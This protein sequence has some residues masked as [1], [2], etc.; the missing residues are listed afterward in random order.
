MSKEQPTADNLRNA[1]D[2]RLLRDAA[3]TNPGGDRSIYDVVQ[4]TDK[5]CTLR[6]IGHVGVVGKS[7]RQPNQHPQEVSGRVAI[8]VER[9]LSDFIPI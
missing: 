9:L 1:K 8:P 5:D 6:N 2:A 3:G 7:S 4:R